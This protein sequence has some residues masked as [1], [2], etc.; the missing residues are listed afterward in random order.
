MQQQHNLQ[1]TVTEYVMAERNNWY[2]GFNVFQYQSKKMEFI[3]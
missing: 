1:H 2:L 3:I